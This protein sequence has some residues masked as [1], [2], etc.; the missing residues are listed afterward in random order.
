[1]NKNIFRI[2]RHSLLRN[3]IFSLISKGFYLFPSREII[4]SWR[5]LRCFL[6]I[7]KVTMACIGI[8]SSWV[9][10]CFISS[11]N[12]GGPLRLNL[13][14]RKSCELV[15]SIWRNRS[16]PF[17]CKISFLDFHW[18]VNLSWYQMGKGKEVSFNVSKLL[19]LFVFC[20][21]LLLKHLFV[22]SLKSLKQIRLY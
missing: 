2:L 5:R 6:E 14:K 4:R 8:L 21:L 9:F 15:G 19:F 3:Q 10:C 7:F 18:L 16:I 20:F 12:A 22:V 1:M 13:L 17:P 11:L